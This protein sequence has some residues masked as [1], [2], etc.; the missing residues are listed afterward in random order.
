MDKDPHVREAVSARVAARLPNLEPEA[1][2]VMVHAADEVAGISEGELAEDLPQDA[3]DACDASLPAEQRK[4]ALY[5]TISRLL[6]A[7]AV[8]GWTYTKKTLAEIDDVTATVANISKNLAVIT[9][10]GGAITS[11][12]WLPKAIPYLLSLL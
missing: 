10:S 8:L 11:P 2:E 12:V 6:R 4:E 9:G 3:R 1:A 7:K 5:K